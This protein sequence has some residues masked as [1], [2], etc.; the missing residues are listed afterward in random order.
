MRATVRRDAGPDVELTE[1]AQR[2][3]T[4]NPGVLCPRIQI[5]EPALGPRGRAGKYCLATTLEIRHKASRPR[6]A[7]RT[8]DHGRRARNQP[9][10]APSARKGCR[11]SSD[12]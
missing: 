12:I 6:F 7:Y 11:F 8:V 10:L 2:M 1:Q 4:R 9:L 3:A 5:V